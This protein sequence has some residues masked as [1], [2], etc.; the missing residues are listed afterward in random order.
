MN[1]WNQF[2]VKINKYGDRV[3][4]T[5]EAT[6]NEHYKTGNSS[7]DSADSAKRRRDMV[8]NSKDDDFMDSTGKSKKRA[9]KR[10][11][12]PVNI[13]EYE[14]PDHYYDVMDDIN[15]DDSIYDVECN[16]SHSNGNQNQNSGGRV[17]PSWS[18]AAG[19]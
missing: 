6:I 18:T 4:E 17:L 16:G 10:T 13:I 7:N 19:N 9:V 14:E 11:N 5:I 2:S 12:Q 1:A 15:F 8:N 3:L